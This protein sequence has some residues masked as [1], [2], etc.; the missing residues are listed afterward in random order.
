MKP[1]NSFDKVALIV[2]IICMVL[3][4]AFFPFLSD[5]IAIQWSG[6][7]VSNTANRLVIFV[8]PLLSLVLFLV[9]FPLFSV[10]LDKRGISVRKEKLI[11]YIVLFVEI[12]LLSSIVSI[13]LFDVGIPVM[14]SSIIILEIIIGVIVGFKIMRKSA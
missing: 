10:C 11:S 3:C 1:R 8:L 5:T 12:L 13:I 2:V 7:D 6:R 14:V 4:V 9:R